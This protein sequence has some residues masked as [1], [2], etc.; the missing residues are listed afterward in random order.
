MRRKYVYRGRR[1]FIH[2]GIG[3]RNFEQELGE[4]DQQREE[5]GDAGRKCMGVEVTPWVLGCRD[6]GPRIKQKEDWKARMSS[7]TQ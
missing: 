1:K 5:V 4:S 3:R 2:E 6:Q 7:E